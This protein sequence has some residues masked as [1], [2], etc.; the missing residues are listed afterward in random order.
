MRR[1]WIDELGDFAEMDPR[2]M[3]YQ[4]KRAGCLEVVKDE[5]RA[6]ED[7]IIDDFAAGAEAGD[8]VCIIV[9]LSLCIAALAYEPFPELQYLRRWLI[10]IWEDV[11][12]DTWSNDEAALDNAS[13]LRHNANRNDR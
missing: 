8:K 3:S 5:A 10:E 6:A 4:I 2:E 11:T 7:A 13:R 12:G 1:D 9:M